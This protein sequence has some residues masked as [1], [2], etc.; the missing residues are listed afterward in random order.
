MDRVIKNSGANPA[1][2]TTEQIERWADLRRKE[3][4]EQHARITTEMAKQHELQLHKAAQQMGK[5][6][7]AAIHDRH[8]HEKDALDTKIYHDNRLLNSRIDQAKETGIIPDKEY[9]PTHTQEPVKAIP[10]QIERWDRIKRRELNDLYW[11]QWDE[12]KKQKGLSG[13]DA[14]SDMV[15]ASIQMVHDARYR[16]QDLALKRARDTGIIPDKEHAPTHTQEEIAQWEQQQRAHITQRQDSEWTDLAR[17]L[18]EKVDRSNINDWLETERA[19]LSTAH[20]EENEAFQQEAK[21]AYGT[22]RLPGQ[23]IQQQIERGRSL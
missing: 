23:E 3:L 16:L 20:A 21:R 14:E 2:A 12:H 17:Q 11:R 5:V 6:S 15:P 7:M 18:R 1:K 19:H 10:E 22:G 8:A 9:A 4:A 13:R